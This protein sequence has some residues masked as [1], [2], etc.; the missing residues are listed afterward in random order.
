MSSKECPNER[1]FIMQRIVNEI[2]RKA[3]QSIGFQRGDDPM[4]LEDYLDLPLMFRCR[5]YWGYMR[6]I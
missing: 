6:V 3:E 4:Q 2:A 5:V 1:D